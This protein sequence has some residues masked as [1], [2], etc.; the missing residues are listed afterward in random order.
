MFALQYFENETN[1]VKKENDLKQKLLKSEINNL[2]SQFQPH[3]LFNSLN[4][5]VAIIDVSKTKAQSML[6]Q[7][8]DIL[9]ISIA[10]TYDSEHT[11]AEE[12]AFIDKF[13]EMEKVRYENQLNYFFDIDQEAYKIKVPKL[14]LQPIVENAIKHGFR[15]N[16]KKLTINVTASSTRG[17][18]QITN[19]GTELNGEFEFGNGLS[20]ISNRLKL[21]YQSEKIFRIYQ[22][23]NWVVNELIMK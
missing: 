18:I 4:S 2:K 1:L 22:C 13:L 6:V 21:L 17:L 23:K 16:Q 19:N 10:N 7:L 11:L 12:I 8:S 14:I 9:R 3:F 15:R 5:I 20:G